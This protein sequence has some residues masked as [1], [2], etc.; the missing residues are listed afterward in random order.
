[1]LWYCS[2]E[3]NFYEGFTVGTDSIDEG[4]IKKGKVK[5]FQ[6]ILLKIGIDYS[7]EER[8][9]NGRSLLY[10]L[11]DGGN[12]IPF[13][14]IASKGTRSFA[15]FYYWYLHI[16]DIAFLAIDEF[17]AYYHS[18][19]AEV[20]VELLREAD[21]QCL[22]TTHNTSIM[23][24]ELLRPD[25]YFNIKNGKIKAFSKIADGEL[26]KIHN[27]SKMFKSGLFENV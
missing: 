24:N 21:V 12:D 20:I 4:I 14:E 22:L 2:L 3:Q 17:D 5:E 19:L 8:E 1:M 6:D 10:V 16:Q 13:F 15:L 7:L 9:I 26:R 18:S 11:F 23:S 25:C 27:L